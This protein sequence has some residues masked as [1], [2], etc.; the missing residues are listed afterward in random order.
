MF[1]VLAFVCKKVFD[2]DS[3]L[4][5][6]LFHTASGRQRQRAS[7]R[8]EGHSGCGLV[9]LG[10]DCFAGLSGVGTFTTQVVKVTPVAL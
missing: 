3:L 7:W 2:M 4:N 5:A 10:K 1:Y 8:A 6:F 9:V